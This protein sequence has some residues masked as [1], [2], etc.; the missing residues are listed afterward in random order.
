MPF[1]YYAG[2]HGLTLYRV[3]SDPFSI[4]FLEWEKRRWRQDNSLA[5]VVVGVG[6]AQAIDQI[7]EKEAREMLESR[8]NETIAGALLD[9]PLP[10]GPV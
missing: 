2:E 10:T 7:T 4:W 1:D 8:Y 9:E 6:G 3:G 5:R